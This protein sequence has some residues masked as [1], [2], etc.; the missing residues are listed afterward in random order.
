MRIL[1][2]R[3]HATFRLGVAGRE[4]VIVRAFAHHFRL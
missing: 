2:F 4:N 1:A 3:D